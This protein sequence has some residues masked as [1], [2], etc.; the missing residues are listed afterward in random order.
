MQT[1]MLNVQHLWIYNQPICQHTM[2]NQKVLVQTNTHLWIYNQPI[3]QK[4]L[5][6][7][8]THLWIYNQPT[9]Q[10]AV[11]CAC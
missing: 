1:S 3:C 6:Q 8:N 2:T 5:V 10:Q 4:V 9:S 11:D 7:T